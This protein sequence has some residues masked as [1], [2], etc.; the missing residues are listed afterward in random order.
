MVD[1]KKKVH[2]SKVKTDEALRKL[3][4][5]KEDDGEIVI[6]LKGR[7][8]RESY[9]VIE[10]QKDNIVKI[11]PVKTDHLV[12]ND[13]LVKFTTAGQNFFTEAKLM[14]D[15]SDHYIL[16]CD[17][18]FYKSERRSS[19]RLLVYPVYDVKIMFLVK[20]GY[21]GSN[22]VNISTGQ[23]ETGIFKS[24]LKV[25]GQDTD[26]NTQE[27]YYRVQDLSTSGVSFVIGEI[28]LKY[29]KK[30]EKLH[31]FKISFDQEEFIV[32]GARVVYVIDYIQFN[33]KGLKQYKVGLEFDQLSTAMD[34][35]LGK[36]IA[37][38]LRKN[39]AN[40]EFEDFIK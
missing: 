19:F 26:A 20:D 34:S 25:L 38:V 4:H 8:I 24:F 13:V 15:E 29:F 33:K 36:K 31:D 40:D 37:D 16:K 35:K 5:L 28:D 11:Y 7:A 32:Q 10:L 21:K 17:K 1:S 30:D 6:W 9:S 18:N 12:N 3:S 23:S 2:F 39:E 14:K 22:I 27:I